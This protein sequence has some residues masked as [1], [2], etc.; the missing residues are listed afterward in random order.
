MVR[1]APVGA[2]QGPRKAKRSKGNPPPASLDAP[3]SAQDITLPPRRTVIVP[4][5]EQSLP[6]E[7]TL[8]ENPTWD[9]LDIALDDGVQTGVSP[10]ASLSCNF[11][12]S[13]PS[14][15]RDNI[16]NPWQIP[17]TALEDQ[18]DKNLD[19][20]MLDSLFWLDNPKSPLQV[21]SPG[22]T[23]P[24]IT[25]DNILHEPRSP[26]RVGNLL[27]GEANNGT[28]NCNDLITTDMDR[29][30]NTTR[31]SDSDAFEQYLLKH[32][33]FLW[34]FNKSETTN[35]TCVRSFSYRYSCSVFLP[36]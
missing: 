23:I 15:E 2:S 29:A 3:Q 21:P 13:S 20:G 19:V 8:T 36:I 1:G 22:G 12:V 18:M 24:A 14:S 33:G 30:L 32:C 27:R 7:S 25:H 9:F 34:K 31:P 6:N 16:Q 11:P 5:K 4:E 17:Q 35:Q 28:Q 10:G 26:T